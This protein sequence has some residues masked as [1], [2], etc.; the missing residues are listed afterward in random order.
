MFLATLAAFGRNGLT[1]HKAMIPLIVLL[2]FYDAGALLAVAPY[3]GER[4]NVMFVAISIYIATT[5]ILFAA[6][7]AR[8]P[9][10][11]FATMRRGYEFA[12]FVASVLGILGYFNVWGLGAIFSAYDNTRAMGPFKDPN[13]FGPFIVVPL[14]WI[15]QDVLL[16]RRRRLSLTT[17]EAAVIVFALLLSLSRGAWGDFVASTIL[18][19]GFTF[20]T[21]AS[22]DL[23]LRIVRLALGGVVAVVVSIG[24]AMSV[25]T[26]RDAILDRTNLDQSYDVGPLGRFGAQVRAVPMLLER[27]FGFGPLQYEKYFPAAP[28]EVYLNAFSAYGWLGGLSF[29]AFTATTLVVGFRLVFGQTPYRNEA[30][31][32]W[33]CLLPQMI[34]G[35]QIDTDH[36]RHLFMMFGILYGLAAATAAAPRSTAPK[37]SGV[38]RAVAISPSPRSGERAQ[39]ADG[40]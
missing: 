24:A 16:G 30:I 18:L 27:P 3:L 6:V 9:L 15:G 7:I 10:D 31:A 4:E 28:H 32:V 26:V 40:V 25:P 35:L 12:A 29:L 36:W 2:A 34:Q 8:D 37:S 1:F 38:R 22:T 5:A 13:V 19:V 11:R 23:R 33:S 14:I 21:T 20:L 39:R 17:L